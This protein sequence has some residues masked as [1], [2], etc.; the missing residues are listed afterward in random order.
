LL[1]PLD[2]HGRGHSE[3]SASP[4]GKIAQFVEA[5]DVASVCGKRPGF[6]ENGLGIIRPASPG[7]VQAF[8]GNLARRVGWIKPC[9][10]L[11]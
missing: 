2:N 5:G 9:I 3:H 11:T 10:V 6:A 7:L 1:E 4:P 8:S